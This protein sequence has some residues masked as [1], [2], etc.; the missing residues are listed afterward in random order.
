VPLVP[1]SF[2]LVVT[3]VIATVVPLIVA[4]VTNRLAPFLLVVAVVASRMP[5]PPMMAIPDRNRINGPRQRIV[6][7]EEE[8]AA[9]R[10]RP[11]PI[12]A[13]TVVPGAS[14][15]IHVVAVVTDVIDPG[16]WDHDQVRL[17]TKHDVGARV[18][19]A[20]VELDVDARCPAGRHYSRERDRCGESSD[21]DG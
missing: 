10:P 13:V 18:S 17:A 5:I 21:A 20:D 14:I 2:P 3:S 8:R 12:H 16:I 6:V 15:P 9:V 1:A 7:N 19:I 11:I 4:V